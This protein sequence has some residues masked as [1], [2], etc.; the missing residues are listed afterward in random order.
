MPFPQNKNVQLVLPKPEHA[1]KGIHENIPLSA[2]EDKELRKK[3]RNRQSALAARERKK[4]RMM[5]LERQVSELQEAQ[6]LLE[7]ENHFLRAQIK[8]IQQKTLQGVPLDK[9]KDFLPQY[10]SSRQLPLKSHAATSS[11]SSSYNAYGVGTFDNSSDPM[12]HAGNQMSPETLY[13]DCCFTS[14]ATTEN[15]SNCPTFSGASRLYST[16]D[17]KY[18]GLTASPQ[19]N[20]FYPS[21]TMC[22]SDTFYSEQHPNEILTLQS[23]QHIKQEAF[24]FSLIPEQIH[25]EVGISELNKIP[26]NCDLNFEG[27][28]SSGASCKMET[29]QPSADIQEPSHGHISPNS[30]PS[31]NAVL[32]ANQLQGTCFKPLHISQTNFK[33]QQLE[34]G[35]KRNQTLFNPSFANENSEISCKNLKKSKSFHNFCGINFPL[36]GSF[37]KPKPY[38][39]KP[40][41]PPYSSNNISNSHSLYSCSSTALTSPV[42]S[43]HFQT[44]SSD[45]IT[46]KQKPHEVNEVFDLDYLTTKTEM[47]VLSSKSDSGLSMDEHLD[48]V[49]T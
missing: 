39:Q 9:E 16:E 14:T 29:P 2:I 36:E 25:Q 46:S 32:Q 1:K 11:S 22:Q 35:I 26:H 21:H 47:E 19:C 15:L 18:K 38:I 44:F 5:E 24:D 48:W 43:A 34:T 4:A 41:A 40:G 28:S 17:K 12:Q 31:I 30:L 20:S 37:D 45:L 23:T 33:S 7:N 6:K 27:S 42:K 13:N 49:P 10:S 3:L 8:I